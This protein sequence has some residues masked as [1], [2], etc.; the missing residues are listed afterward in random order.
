MRKKLRNSTQR[1]IVNCQLSIFVIMLFACSSYESAQ[2]GETYTCPMH[3]T[4]VADKPGSCPVCGMDLVLKAQAGEEVVITKELSQLIKS[5]N[6]IVTASIKTVRGEYK[7]VPVVKELLGIVTYDTRNVYTI[8][9]RI[10]GRL[11]KVFLKYNFQPVTKGMKIAEVYSPELIS[12]QRELIFLIKNDAD[13][14][15]LI[16]GATRRLKFLGATEKQVADLM[17]DQEVRNTFSIYSPYDG[18]V[19]M[20][21]QSPALPAGASVTTK[22][23]G[24][25]GMNSTEVSSSQPNMDNS[26]SSTILP[27]EGSYVT[28]GQVLFKIV[29]ASATWI[30]F[31]L[32]SANAEHIKKGDE[33]VLAVE[34]ESEKVKVDFIEPFSKQS[35][36]FVTIRAY[37]RN[38]KLLIGQLIKGAITVNNKSSLWLPK[39]AVLDLGIDQIVFIREKDQFRS[40]KVKSGLRGEDSIQIISGITSGDEVA[41]DAHYL[42]DSEGFVKLTN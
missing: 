31:Q 18:Y 34:N 4:V 17:K 16:E 32:S 15:S 35:N 13:N 36:D 40:V 29:N 28:A 21:D 25:M 37:T 3:P 12:T 39:A 10:G 38:S 26:V 2:Q 30:E 5:P 6:K 14:K 19:T 20:N 11:E 42:V 27:R 23:T 9:T 24:G 8:P 1:I 41:V 22:K 7:S 33:I